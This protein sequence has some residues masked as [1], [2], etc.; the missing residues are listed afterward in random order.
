MH[1]KIKITGGFVGFARTYEGE[2]DIS[3]TQLKALQRISK[4]NLGDK[5]VF[6][7]GQQYN[8]TLTDNEQVYTLEFTEQE[9]PQD[10]MNLISSLKGG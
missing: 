8:L 9:I 1:Y 2:T 4:S 5:K 3:L 7:D 6:R 10:L